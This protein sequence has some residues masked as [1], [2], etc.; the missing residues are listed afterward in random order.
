MS[1]PPSAAA[2]R[3]SAAATGR[4]RRRRSGARGRRRRAGVAAT[5]TRSAWSI[6]PRLTSLVAG[7]Q[8]QDRQPG[9]V[10][11]RPARRAEPRSSAGS[12]SRRSPR[13]QRAGRPCEVEQLVEPAAAAVDAAARGGRRRR[14]GRPRCGPRAGSGSGR[15]RTRRRSRS[16]RGCSACA[17]RPRRTG[18]RS[19]GPRRGRS[20]SRRG[21]PRPGR[22]SA[23]I[24]SEPGR[25]GRWST[26]WLVGNVRGSSGQPAMRRAPARARRGRRRERGPQLR[27]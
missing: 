20:R 22:S 18:S 1:T 5:V 24:A 13:V 3:P 14:R 6:R 23:T 7:E 17:G 9:G 11:R 21:G 26:R 4:G 15:G 19:A 8:R 16:A 10:G 27:H 2:A 25:D 12:T